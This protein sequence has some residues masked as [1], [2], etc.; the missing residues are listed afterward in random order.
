M[1][2]LLASE[3]EKMFVL[4]LLLIVILGVLV[5][6]IIS[7]VRNKLNRPKALL[8]KKREAGQVVHD[9]AVRQIR[10]VKRSAATL[11][12]IAVL[13]AV[14]GMV[15]CHSINESELA[16][17]RNARNHWVSGDGARNGLCADVEGRTVCGL[18][19]GG[20]K[21]GLFMFLAATVLAAIPILR[22]KT[23]NEKVRADVV[24]GKVAARKSAE[25]I[26]NGQAREPSLSESNW[27]RNA[28]D[29]D[30]RKLYE[31]L[32]EEISPEVCRRDGCER[33]RVVLSVMCRAHHYEMVLK[34]PCP[35]R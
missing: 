11:P 14:S 6:I 35:F 20:F 31:S 9:D 12:L 28:S 19:K 16:R 22:L 5:M 27:M 32:G 15:T 4:G 21:I 10:E 8:S 18:G 7:H 1:P 23:S 2:L 25:I 24:A 17:Y 33:K 13:L 30:D 3:A 29:V 26:S 34:H